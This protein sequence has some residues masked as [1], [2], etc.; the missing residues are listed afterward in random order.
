MDELQGIAEGSRL[1]LDE[2]V[3]ITLHEEVG[4]K[5][6]SPKVHHCTALAAG[7][8]DTNDGNMYVGQNWDWMRSAYGLS[9][10]LLWKRSEGPSVLAYSYPGMWI[11]AGLNSSGIALCWTWG[12]QRGIQGSRTGIPSYVLVA[13][14]LYQDT[15]NGALDEARRAT[16]AGWF[17]FVLADG[18]SH[19]AN[20]EGTP[21]KLVIETTGGHLARAD[22]GT[23][24]ITD[25]PPGQPVEYDPKCQRMIDLLSART[26]TLDRST[27]QS[28]FADHFD[29]APGLICVHDECWD[30]LTLDSM[31]FNCTTREAHIQ[32]GPGCSNRWQYFRFTD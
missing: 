27:L 22:F 2:A 32:R 1:S 20:V 24:A 23:R 13:Q 7:P 21:E 12:D 19:L 4:K 16:N 18:E 14:M 28:L 3:V 17:N 15:L 8:P 9:S 6:S 5:E 25:T 26:G 29:P 31:L 30:P 11:G 10:M